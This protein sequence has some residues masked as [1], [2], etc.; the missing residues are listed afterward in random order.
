MDGLRTALESAAAHGST[1]H[2]PLSP[3][4]LRNVLLGSEPSAEE[5]ARIFQALSETPLYR[6]ATLGREL[7]LSLEELDNRFSILF[8]IPLE[9]AQ[10]WTPDGH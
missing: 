3:Q 9:K 5:S 6:L 4:R 10:Q 7:G 2:G 1:S 8:G